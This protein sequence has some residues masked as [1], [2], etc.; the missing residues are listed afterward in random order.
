MRRSLF[1]S[2][3]LVAATLFSG[4]AG[5]SIQRYGS[6]VRGH[7]LSTGAARADIF[8][9][10]GEPDVIYAG[11]DQTEIFV[12]K[13]LK[14]ANYFGLYAKAKRL[15]TIV[16]FNNQGIV[17]SVTEIDHG[18][19]HTFFSA[20]AVLDITHPFSSKQLTNAGAEKIGAN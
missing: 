17:E 1:L 8:A 16:V 20:P 9:S 13:G 12:Y 5:L 15:D 14:G 10:V 11:N 19:G 6:I 18:M 3:A 7:Q 4:C 2:F